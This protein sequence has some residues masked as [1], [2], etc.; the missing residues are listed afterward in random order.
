MNAKK[1]IGRPQ[2]APEA[3]RSQCVK[4]RLTPDEFQRLQA[5]V[6]HVGL[7]TPASLLRCIVLLSL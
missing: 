2:L 1:K 4:V 3:L 5:K 7:K 6:G